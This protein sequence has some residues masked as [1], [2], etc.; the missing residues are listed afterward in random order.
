MWKNGELIAGLLEERELNGYLFKIY[1]EQWGYC[2][3]I[4]ENDKK[5]GAEFWTC[6]EPNCE[7][8]DDD[9]MELVEK[10]KAEWLLA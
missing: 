6:P 1:D 10:L 8:A 7:P 9:L 3:E 5:I 4:W 2:V